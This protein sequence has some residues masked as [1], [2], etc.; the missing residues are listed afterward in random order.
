MSINNDGPQATVNRHASRVRS[1]L[2]Y[3]PHGADED[4]LQK[5]DKALSHELVRVYLQ[6]L[7]TG[8]TL[9]ISWKQPWPS[10]RLGVT[11]RS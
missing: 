11:T 6:Y 3:R 10:G 7:G 1:A 9:K 5:W 4:Y 8:L 2:Y